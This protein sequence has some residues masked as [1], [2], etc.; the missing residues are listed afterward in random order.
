MQDING[1]SEKRKIGI[2]GGTFNPIHIG[3]LIIAEQAY[4]Q[5]GLDKVLFLPA[6]EPPHKRQESIE[7]DQNRVEMVK[8]A[9]EANP[10]FELSL[11]EMERDSISYT[12][13]TLKQLTR[14]YPH[15]EFYFIVGGD[16]IASIEQWR[17]PGTIMKL[18]HL[19]ACVRNDMDDEK[20]TMQ[21]AY[22]NDKYQANV[23]KLN[24]PMM[25]I[26]STS[27]R[28]RTKNHQSNRYMVPDKVLS[29]IS[30]KQ[31]YRK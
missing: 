22:L 6:N 29:F 8:L 24:I 28:N 16:S 17:E 31:L 15:T 12:V 3:H 14:E 2:M 11:V 18:C 30:N 13:D 25:D 23:H 9:I 20:L 4:E 7:S 21:I 1:I 10:H 5:Y 26:S 19:L 27:I